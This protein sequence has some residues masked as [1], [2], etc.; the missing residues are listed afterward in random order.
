MNFVF[1]Q[2][3][4]KNSLPL[5]A[6]TVVFTIFLVNHVENVDTGYV[7]M[8]EV[9]LAVQTESW[10]LRLCSNKE[11][12]FDLKRKTIP[13]YILLKIKKTPPFKFTRFA[14]ITESMTHIMWC[15]CPWF[16]DRLTLR[17]RS[18]EIDHLISMIYVDWMSNVIHAWKNLLIQMFVVIH[19]NSYSNQRYSLQKNKSTLNFNPFNVSQQRNNIFENEFFHTMNHLKKT[20]IA[21]DY[22]VEIHA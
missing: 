5:G 9:F 13:Y 15:K 12:D 20:H 6:T 7:A 2:W 22:P 3:N 11:Q 16:T 10:V 17:D 1:E 8:L 14:N 21:L 19:W 18:Q 4:E